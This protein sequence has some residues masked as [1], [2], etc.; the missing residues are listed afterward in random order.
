MYNILHL[1]QNVLFRFV[2]METQP[3]DVKDRAVADTQFGGDICS[4]FMGLRLVETTN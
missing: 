4:M 3:K 2:E 1:M